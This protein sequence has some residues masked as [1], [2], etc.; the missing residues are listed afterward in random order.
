MRGRSAGHR[1]RIMPRSG[2]VHLACDESLWLLGRCGEVRCSI[3]T[4]ARLDGEEA[5]VV[6]LDEAVLTGLIKMLIVELGLHHRWGGA[7]DLAV[8]TAARRFDQREI[9]LVRLTF[10]IEGW[11]GFG[12]DLDPLAGRGIW[13]LDIDLV[14]LVGAD[15]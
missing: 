3:E 2:T 15:Q 4:E 13:H 1:R 5:A 14:I 10:A 11:T 6:E 8:I 12:A 9:R 7:H